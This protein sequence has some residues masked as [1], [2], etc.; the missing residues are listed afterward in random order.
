MSFHEKLVQHFEQYVLAGKKKMTEHERLHFRAGIAMTMGAMAEI[1]QTCEDF[2]E[3]TSKNLD[4][5]RENQAFGDTDLH[6][7]HAFFCENCAKGEQH[8][9][10]S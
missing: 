7:Y 5:L 10:K 6:K 9:L 8:G 4:I 3:F 1:A 2:G